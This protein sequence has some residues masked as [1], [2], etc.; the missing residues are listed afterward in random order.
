MGISSTT[1]MLEYKHAPGDNGGAN[2]IFFLLSIVKVANTH[3]K[4]PN[5]E[6]DV[7]EVESDPI[8]L[9]RPGRSRTRSPAQGATL[10]FCP[11]SCSVS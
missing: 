2:T 7:R 8:R 11:V 1:L 6:P 5:A 9:I 4:S 3:V 10:D